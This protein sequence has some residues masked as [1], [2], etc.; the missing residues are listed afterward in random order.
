LS[1]HYDAV[2][3]VTYEVLRPVRTCC[4]FFSVVIPRIHAPPRS[5]SR[6]PRAPPAA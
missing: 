6:T 4:G 2:V 3:S 1:F 5:E